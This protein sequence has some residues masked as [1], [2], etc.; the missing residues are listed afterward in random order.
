MALPC[1]RWLGDGLR[2]L[3]ADVQ[4]MGGSR[5]LRINEKWYVLWLSL[6][7]VFVLPS[8][9]EIMRGRLAIDV[10]RVAQNARSLLR[11]YW[12]PSVRWVVVC[13]LAAGVAMTLLTRVNAF[14]YF[15]F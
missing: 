7:A 3:G 14:I 8:T 2:A 4:S 12:R 11:F 6:A 15:Q 10:T 13:G 5:N 9:H 1:K